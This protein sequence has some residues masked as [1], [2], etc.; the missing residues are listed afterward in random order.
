[1]AKNTVGFTVADYHASK[2]VAPEKIKGDAG[3]IERGLNYIASGAA[4]TYVAGGNFKTVLDI[5][6]TGL[7]HVQN[8]KNECRVLDNVIRI[9]QQM[10]LSAKRKA[11]LEAQLASM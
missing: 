4:V 1:M 3:W 2:S 11:A 6:A 9:N 5:E 10:A 7:Q 8:V